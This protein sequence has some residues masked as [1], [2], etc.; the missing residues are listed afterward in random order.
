MFREKEPEEG[1]LKILERFNIKTFLT[2]NGEVVINSDGKT[3]SV[4][5]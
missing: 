1:V 3:L 2:S 5:Q 4:N